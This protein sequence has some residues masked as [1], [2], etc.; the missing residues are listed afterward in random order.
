MGWPVRDGNSK[1]EGV[2]SEP[3]RLSVILPTLGRPQELRRAVKS[4]L[5]WRG[6]MPTG[7]ELLV[8]FD[9]S[10]RDQADLPY[11]GVRCIV[12]PAALTLARKMNQLAA[13]ARGEWLMPLANDMIVTALDWPE[14]IFAVID[15]L[16]SPAIL[17]V[18]DP[19]H[20]GFTTLPIL[21]RG[22]IEVSKFFAAPW[23]PFWFTDTWWD[24]IAEF[25]GNRIA[26]DIGLTNPEGRGKSHVLRDLKFWAEF[27]EATRPLRLQA[28]M[29]MLPP[30]EHHRIAVRARQARAKVAHIRHPSFIA[31]WEGKAEVSTPV[32]DERYTH[33][34]AEAETFLASIPRRLMVAIC[35]PSGN[36]WD[37]RTGASI[38]AMTAYS[39]HAGIE[40]AICGLQGSVISDQRNCLVDIGI[41]QMN[42]D[43]LLFIDSDMVFPPDTLVRLIGHG[44]DIVGATYCKRVPPYATLGRLLGDKPSDEEL[45]QG[46]LREAAILPGG[47]MLIK[48]SVFL[49]MQAPW[50]HEVYKWEGERG[51]DALR[52][53]LTHSLLTEVPCEVAASIDGSLLGRWLDQAWQIEKAVPGTYRSEDSTFCTN[54]RR[55][56]FKVWCDLGLTFQTRHVGMQEVTC[57]PPTLAKADVEAVP[58]QVAEAAD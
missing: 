27:F 2:L 9:E 56:G 33:A 57:L 40:M 16:R 28:A 39:S 10:E 34:K 21:H 41:N 55:A 30:Q 31:E 14:R 24:E 23:F 22:Q 49:T 38:S 19:L 46:G 13:E 52:S 35:I 51:S 7:T 17:H 50:F 25:L 29:A 47:L 45:N 54:A 8:G 42:A 6:R 12:A 18:D 15:H 26:I 20:P 4:L 48:S 3:I 32:L 58:A 11:E 43:Y 36:T 5:G 44:K 37:A 53:F 1:I